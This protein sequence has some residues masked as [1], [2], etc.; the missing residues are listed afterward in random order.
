[1]NANAGAYAAWRPHARSIAHTE[2]YV[3]LHCCST[4]V[5]V[6]RTRL[7]ITLYVHCLSYCITKICFHYLKLS[8]TKKIQ[9]FSGVRYRNDVIAIPSNR[10]RHS[11]A[12]AAHSLEHF[13]IKNFCLNKGTFL[14][15]RD[16][17]AC[18]VLEA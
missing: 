12:L 14:A 15:T 8:G 5:M 13:L 17:N 9:Q 7:N 10:Y 18:G 11:T 6:S 1:M 16:T 2:K 4:T 3:T